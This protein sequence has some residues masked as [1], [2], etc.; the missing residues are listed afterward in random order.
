MAE[1]FVAQVAILIDAPRAKVWDALVNPE[2]IKQ[3]L[4][5]TSVVSEWHQGS[6]I[7]WTSE[8]LDKTFEVRG[9]V[10]SLREVADDCRELSRARPHR[11]VARRQVDVGDVAQLG[12][13][14]EPRLALFDGVLV[15]RGRVPGADDRTRHVEA[16]VV[17][18]R[19]CLA[20]CGT[21]LRYGP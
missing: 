1:T 10:L 11:P 7:V 21:G 17:R 20:Q 9:T 15:L 2:K 13:T 19:G 8:F 16:R 4:P 12:E 14:A 6:S 5:V 18:K 3:Y